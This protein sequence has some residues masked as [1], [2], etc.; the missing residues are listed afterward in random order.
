MALDAYVL[1]ML[2]GLLPRWVRPIAFSLSL[3]ISDNCSVAVHEITRGEGR[4]ARSRPPTRL[5]GVLE[6]LLLFAEMCCGRSLIW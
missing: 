1:V 4:R 3:S 2:Q 6:G 5:L